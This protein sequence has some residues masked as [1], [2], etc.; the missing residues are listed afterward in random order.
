[1]TEAFS[2]FFVGKFPTRKK[3]K[4]SVPWKKGPTRKKIPALTERKN[5]FSAKKNLFHGVGFE[6]KEKMNQIKWKKN[7]KYQKG[8]TQKSFVWLGPV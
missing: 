4:L 2:F 7:V 5:I 6:M 1:M 3:K 8:Y